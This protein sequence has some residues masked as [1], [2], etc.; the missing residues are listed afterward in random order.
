MPLVDG[1]DGNFSIEMTAPAGATSL[2]F[3]LQ[4][5]GINFSSNTNGLGPNNV[6]YTETIN[7]NSLPTADAGDNEMICLG[8]QVELGEVG[9][10]QGSAMAPLNCNGDSWP[11]SAYISNV[12][13]EGGVTN[14]NNTTGNNA[15]SQG[16]GGPKDYTSTN[17]VEVIHGNS[18]DLRITLSG[19]GNGNYVRVWLDKDNNGS[20]SATEAVGSFNAS[21]GGTTT[22]AISIPTNDLEIGSY[23]ILVRCRESSDITAGNACAPES[24]PDKYGEM[25]YY[26]L[27]VLDP[28][29]YSWSPATNLSATDVS[30]PTFTPTST[31]EFTYELTL[32][33]NATGCTAT[34]EVTVTV[35]DKPVQVGV[36]SGSNLVCVG[37]TITYS[38]DPVAD[39]TEY[40]WSVPNGWTINSGH[41]TT[42]INVTAGTNAI[43]GT[44]GVYALNDCGNGT[45]NTIS[46]D[47]S[48]TPNPTLSFSPNTNICQGTN[49]TYTTESGKSNYTWEIPGIEGSDYTLVSGGAS[50]NNTV[51]IAWNAASAGTS[52][53]VNYEDGGC[54]ASTPATAT[55]I[56][57]PNIVTSLAENG[58]S[59][60]C[61]INGENPI[62]FYSTS[63]KK[64]IGSINPNG[65][66]GVVTMTAY[67]HD[68]GSN[69]G[70]DDGTMYACG[71]MGNDLYRTAFMERSFVINPVDEISGSGNT[72]V[73]LPFTSTEF[74]NLEV[75]ST[76][77]TVGN[78]EDDIADVADLVITKYHSP[79][80]ENGVPYD[81]CSGGISSLIEQAESGNISNYGV[82]II[83]SY[84]MFKMSDFSEIY[85]HGYNNVASPLPIELVSFIVECQKNDIIVNWTTASETNSDIFIVEKS[86]NGSN[87]QE[88]ET[89]DAAGNS[90]STI[91]YSITDNDSWNGVSYYRLRQLDFDGKEEVFGPI[92]VSCVDNGNSMIVFPNPSNGNFTVEINSNETIDSAT[93][94][95]MD[96][97]GRILSNKTVDITTGVNQVY[98]DNVDLKRGTYIVRLLGGEKEFTPVKAVVN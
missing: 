83:A 85:L 48:N 89:I 58:E 51:V 69:P 18:F 13:S 76:S 19:N 50:T 77:K 28:Y 82:P 39:A 90:T 87:W 59:A 93:V 3:D 15:N 17:F 10:L 36:I 47:V 38:I 12:K 63:S 75:A 78:A 54:A 34:D 70:I 20:F 30:D 52:V 35:A 84:A 57:L 8:G 24:S 60:T 26:K 66:T 32:T 91:N 95:L 45:G 56:T 41:N 96:Y 43:S 74:D 25:E 79:G 68:F 98:F 64:Y 46:V 27:V 23:R 9:L 72:D 37:E 65:R 1:A 53:Q 31:G 6:L 88:V 55:E 7:V 42:S 2:A 80:N 49:V 44:I 22:Q 61:Y 86:R 21:G 4:K 14:F 40:T 67:V 92:S 71:G 29:S 16:N 81:N 97:M 94:Q 62:H 11:G 33:D 73:Y 5:D